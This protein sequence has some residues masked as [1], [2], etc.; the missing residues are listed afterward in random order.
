MTSVGEFMLPLAAA[1]LDT[2]Y[3][4]QTHT[5]T[6]HTPSTMVHLLSPLPPE[7]N[8]RLNPQKMLVLLVDKD[9]VTTKVLGGLPGLK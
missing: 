5:H 9:S 3:H 2:R 8:T 6:Q 4:R 7:C 1:L